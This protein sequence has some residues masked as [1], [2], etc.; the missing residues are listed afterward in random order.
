ME[1]I[2][3]GPITLQDNDLFR[4]GEFY[5]HGIGDRNTAAAEL[6]SE[7]PILEKT[8]YSPWQN[9]GFLH[10]TATSKLR[11][12]LKTIVLFPVQ[13]LDRRTHARTVDRLASGVFLITGQ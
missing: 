7:I 1:Q 10:L 9:I 6:Q 11:S 8:K 13:L 3:P 4:G 12:H 2:L 5:A